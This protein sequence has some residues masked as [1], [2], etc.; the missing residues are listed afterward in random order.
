MK[1]VLVHVVYLV[2]LLRL[3][4]TGGNNICC[5]QMTLYYNLDFLKIY[6]VLV[7]ECEVD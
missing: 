4:A 7:N 3:Y 6:F 2:F 5:N 1:D